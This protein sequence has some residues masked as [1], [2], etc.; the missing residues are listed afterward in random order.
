MHYIIGYMLNI[1]AFTFINNA[2]TLKISAYAQCFVVM[3]LILMIL[4]LTCD[5]SFRQF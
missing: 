3:R 1:Y 4:P 2:H 5:V